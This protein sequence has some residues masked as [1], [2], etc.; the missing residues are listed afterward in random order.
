MEQTI[1]TNSLA[2]LYEKSQRQ[3]VTLMTNMPGMAYRYEGDDFNEFAFV[4]EGCRQ[5]T[6]YTAKDFLDQQV[7]FSSLIPPSDRAR[8]FDAAREALAQKR[9][10]TLQYEILTASGQKKWVWEQGCGVFSPEGKLLSI[11]G[12]ICDI[13]ERKLAE[14]V[15]KESEEFHRSIFENTWD[16]MS[17]VGLNG[18]FVEIN[19]A[20]CRML[21]YTRE[22]LL[23]KHVTSIIDPERRH[24]WFDFVKG[25]EHDRITDA[26]AET[27]DVRKDGS[28]LDLEISSSVLTLQGQPMILTVCRDISERKRASALLSSLVAEGDKQLVRVNRELAEEIAE[29]EKIEM[30]LRASEARHR[31]LMNTI[32]HGVDEMDID[33]TILFANV[34]LHRLYGCAQGAL[35]GQSVYDRVS[36]DK[37]REVL[38]KHLAYLAKEHPEPTPYIGKKITDDGREIEVQVDWDYNFAPDGSVRSFTTVVTDITERRNAEQHLSLQHSELAHVTRV[39]TMGEMATGIAHEL[40]QPLAAIVNYTRGCIRRLQAKQIDNADELSKVMQQ[41]SDEAE[42]AA[43]I[44]QRM[45][46]FVK[47]SDLA[48]SALNVNDVVSESLQF[49]DYEVNK[50][51]IHVVVKLARRP[52]YVFADRVQLSQVLVNIIRNAIEAVSD[53]APERRNITLEV[54]LEQ[55]SRVVIKIRNAGPA[56]TAQEAE[57]VFDPFYTTK[58]TGLGMG[59]A[60]SRTIIEAH[61]GELKTCSEELDGACFVILLPQ[62]KVPR[63]H[64]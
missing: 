22:E 26:Y 38:R 33:G 39:S 6:G 48:Q 7:K 16:G 46:N 15:L 62:S 50:R 31:S 53:V 8:V 61:G 18:Y 41:V 27:V 14:R 45:R 20:F 5:L 24:Q 10:F 44:I 54:A 60:I 35:V 9:P 25:Y 12:F 51:N 47:K 17:I 21:G 59:L 58:S 63:N 49:F 1:I 11:E 43:A 34:A 32:P 37:E 28:L 36:T 57:K 3:L 56:L 42:R 64:E 2:D 23:Q 4:S 52:L 30:A 55:S 40:N 29:R 19:P 13:T